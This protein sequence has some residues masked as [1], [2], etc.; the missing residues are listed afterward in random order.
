MTWVGRDLTDDLV[1]TPLHGQGHVLVH[2]LMCMLGL[3]TSW[4]SISEQSVYCEQN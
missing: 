4:G 2:D 1:L 3:K